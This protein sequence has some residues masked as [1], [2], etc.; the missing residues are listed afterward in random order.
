MTVT[1]IR[2]D[3]LSI[4]LRGVSRVVAEAALDGLGAELSRRLA[5]QPV[6]ALP[7][8]DVFRIHLAD[9]EIADPRDITALREAIAARVV[10]G[11]SESRNLVPQ[12][13]PK[14]GGS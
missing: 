14:G 1:R 11:L 2:L 7:T 9:D 4:R 6:S 13:G 10:V 8:G 12:A 5:R 3:Q